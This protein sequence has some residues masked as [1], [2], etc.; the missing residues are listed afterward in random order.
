MMKVLQVYLN[1]IGRSCKQKF[2]FSYKN[3]QL[4]IIL[5]LQFKLRL[6]TNYFI[7]HEFW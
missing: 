7:K 1:N 3:Q 2:F 5:N 6:F 4:Q